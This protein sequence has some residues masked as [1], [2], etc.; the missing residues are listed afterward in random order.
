[1][2]VSITFH[3]NMICELA[4]QFL[5][6]AGHG[7][8]LLHCICMEVHKDMVDLTGN[9]ACS[10]T[11]KMP[12]CACGLGSTCLPRYAQLESMPSYG[13]HLPNQA[14]GRCHVSVDV[15]ACVQRQHKLSHP[16]SGCRPT[17]TLGRA[18]HVG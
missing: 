17:L 3:F 11:E 2:L 5:M 14:C 10:E 8:W 4:I 18:R 6:L 1:M 16:V 12:V 7:P 9:V 13:V 15:D